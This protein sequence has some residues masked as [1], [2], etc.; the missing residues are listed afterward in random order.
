MSGMR[1]T[2]GVIAK[3]DRGFGDFD[4]LDHIALEEYL[5]RIGSRLK[6]TYGG[7]MV[8]FIQSDSRDGEG[9]LVLMNED[10]LA[11][12]EEEIRLAN[13]SV[14]EGTPKIFVD[15]W[16]DGCDPPHLDITLEQA[17][18]EKEWEDE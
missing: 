10:M 18:Y 5:E 12:F 15:N 7:D 8:V 2:V 3:L 11:E 1:L 6:L 4:Q 13:L 14:L 16:Y 9:G 17:G